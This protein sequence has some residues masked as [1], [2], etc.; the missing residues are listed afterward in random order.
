MRITPTLLTLLAVASA[1][2]D[3]IS[4]SFSGN[5]DAYDRQIFTAAAG[6]WNGV[7]TGFRADYLGD[8][9]L[10]ASRG[11]SI[12]ADITAIDGVGAT[13]GSAGPTDAIYHDNNPL[14]APTYA[15]LYASTGTMRFDSADVHLLSDTAYF[16]VVLHEMGHVL[17]IGTLWSY[18]TDP[19][20]GAV[21]NP[22]YDPATANRSLFN[23]ELVGE[24]TGRFA[25]AGWNAEFNRADTFV[26]IETGGGE[27][28]T[29][30]HWNE[31]DGGLD[32][33]LI[34]ATTGLDFSHELMTGWAND[35]MFLSEVT[36]GS[37]EDLGF[38]VDHTKA[39]LITYAAV[40]EAGPLP[41]LAAGALLIG[42][43][44]RLRRSR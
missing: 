43:R 20:Y 21:D 17:G 29:D 27:G 8:G 10:P 24:Y 12:S 31:G 16:S 28:T 3:Y 34:S 32:T 44:R 35:A 38:E 23:G 15:R 39:G 40:P 14:G 37:L 41:A 36:L 6:F 13:L 18:N 30:S 9:T 19:A 5:E 7:I 1:R 42:L 26:P 11:L 2:A 33:G 4:L 22:M 25:L